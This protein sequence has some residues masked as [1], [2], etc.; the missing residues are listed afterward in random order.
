MTAARVCALERQLAERDAEIA[1][2]RRL[3]LAAAR[4]APGL[5]ALLDAGKNS[6]EG[7]ER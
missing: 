6:S 5:A 4:T 3:I 1:G 7:E 2:L